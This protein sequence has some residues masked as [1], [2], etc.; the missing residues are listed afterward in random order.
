MGQWGICFWNFFSNNIHSTM[1]Q[2][3]SVQKILNNVEWVYLS[4]D[5]LVRIN[6][7]DSLKMC[8][9]MSLPKSSCDIDIYL[10]KNECINWDNHTF[11]LSIPSHHWNECEHIK[12][13]TCMKTTN[14]F[15]TTDMF[16]AIG[17]KRILLLV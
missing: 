17:S 11:H 12:L 7:L 8:E 10:S 4:T 5:P 3:K 6:Q 16:T 15:C 9:F 14:C 13:K 1:K 2:C